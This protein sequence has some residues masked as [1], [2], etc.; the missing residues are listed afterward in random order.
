MYLHFLSRARRSG[1]VVD[2][3]LEF[4]EVRA[5]PILPRRLERATLPFILI[6]DHSLVFSF[7]FKM[8]EELVRSEA[9][10]ALKDILRK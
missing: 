8:P 9:S 5:N 1:P 10:I 4:I 3:I 6:D 2:Q 7:V